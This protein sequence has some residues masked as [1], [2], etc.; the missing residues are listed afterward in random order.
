MSIDKNKIERVLRTN[1]NILEKKNQD[2]SSMNLL[3][4]GQ[5]GIVTRLTD[6]VARLRNLLR[7]DGEINFESIADTFGDIANYGIIGQLMQEG[8]I[9]GDIRN[10]F[11]MDEVSPV[12]EDELRNN[13]FNVVFWCYIDPG[14]VHSQRELKIQMIDWADAVVIE[15]TDIKK[16]RMIEYAVTGGKTVIILDEFDF[17]GEE[18]TGCTMCNDTKKLISLL[19]SGG[20]K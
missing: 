15:H 17:E 10:A 7:K 13:G 8:G 12:I 1:M 20:L 19:S 2:Y 16:A 4:E 14:M 18:I 9:L 5:P 6:K 3:I 11:V